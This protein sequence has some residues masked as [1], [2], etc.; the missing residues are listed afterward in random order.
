VW[1][2]NIDSQA[3]YDTAT[4]YVLMVDDVKRISFGE[5]KRDGVDTFQMYEARATEENI[6]RLQEGWFPAV[7]TP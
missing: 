4:S 1:P 6:F 5:E 3:L 7:R 2:Q